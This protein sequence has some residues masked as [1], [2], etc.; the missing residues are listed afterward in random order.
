MTDGKRVLGVIPARGGS[1]R[2]PRKN[3]RTVGGIPLIGHAVR[4][5]NNA[6]SLNEVV[7]STDDEA[8]ASIAKEY[9]GDVPFIRPDEFATDDASSAAV[10]LHTLDWYRDQDEKF[11]AIAMIQPTTPLR[12]ATDI[13]ETVKQLYSS[14]A[15]AAM[16]VSE[17]RVPPQWAVTMAES[18]MLSPYLKDS[19][20]WTDE[21]IPRSQNLSSL[22]HPNGAAFVAYVSAFREFRGFYTDHVIGHEMPFVR[23]ID[24][25]TLDDL[26]LARALFNSEDDQN[27]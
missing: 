8:I 13:N 14:D 2:V 1:K 17:Y 18:G 5:A 6:K 10:L 23:S 27:E 22:L 4:Q 12:T 26:K 20:L 16:S 24:V 11:D 25:D 21:E 9:G 7:V 15:T 19:P 3:V